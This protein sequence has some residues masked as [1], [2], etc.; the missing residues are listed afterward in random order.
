[1][2]PAKKQTVTLD[3]DALEREESPEPFVARVGGKV[4]RL[5][6][7]AAVSWNELASITS[8]PAAFLSV[9][10]PAKQRDEFLTALAELPTWKVNKLSGAY[11]QHFA[12]TDSAGP[13]ASPTS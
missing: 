12:L 13:D 5:V 4:Y 8:A 11:R 10:V 9:A 1:M 2:A 7:P 6:D 3:L